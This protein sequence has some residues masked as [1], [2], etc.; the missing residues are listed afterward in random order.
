[1]S[2]LGEY[3]LRCE[4]AG[5]SKDVRAVTTTPEGYIV[6]ASRDT[7][8]KLWL[9]L[10]DGVHYE[11]KQ[12]YSGHTSYVS[13]VCVLPGGDGAQSE[14]PLV[15]TGS[16][17]TT[18]LVYPL[19]SNVP[20]HTLTGHSDTVSCLAWGEGALVSGS[21]DCTGRVWSGW[22]CIHELKGHEGPL[23][24][25]TI[26][27]GHSTTTILT[28][29]A[30]KTIRMW[31]G[32]KECH[33]F[34]GHKDCVRGLAVLSTD[35]FLSC[36][37]DATVILWSITGEALNT[38]EGHTNFIYG[39]ALICGEGD[40]VTG[41]E[42]RTVRVWS[43]SAGD[44]RQVIH[45]P[46]QSVWAVAALPN[47]DI[48]CGTSDG[49]CRV[50]S[51]VT[52]RQADTASQKVFEESVAKSTMAVGDLGGIKKSDLPG[53]EVLLTPGKKDGHTVMVREGDKINCYSW[54]ASKQEWTAVGE[55]VGGAGGSTSTSGKVLFEGKEY[56][57]V[58][59]VELDQGMF[60]KLPYNICEDPY[61]AA[62]RFIHHHELPQEFLDKVASF[63]IQNTKGTSLG[64]EG[65]GQ[66]SDPFTGGARYQPTT[67]DGSE[68]GGIGEGADPFT[69][70]GRYVPGG[71]SRG[72]NIGSVGVSGIPDPFT[73]ASSY[74]TPAARNVLAPSHFFPQQV[75]LRFEACNM[76]G[77]LSKL[78]ASN[79]AIDQSHQLANEKL[80]Q[81][82]ACV[83]EAEAS[84]PNHLGPLECAL[85]WPVEHVWPALDVLRLALLS[86]KMQTVWLDTDRRG[87]L[88]SHL[89]SF[90][91]L[92]SVPTAQM[93]AL[94][95]L[96]NL[97]THQPGRQALMEM[98]DK[99]ITVTVEIAPYQNKNA[100]IAASTVL[101][102]YTVLLEA[103]ENNSEENLDKKCQVM[104]GAGT[105]AMTAKDP[106][107]Q[108]RCLVALGTLLH[109][110][111]NNNNNRCR[112]LAAS[113]DLKPVVERLAKVT[114]PTKVGECASHL[115]QRL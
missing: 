12:T 23:W 84:D 15:A 50:F 106:E 17:D 22:Q 38:Y 3:R 73:G 81:L 95:C 54:S 114:S 56:D 48:V 55:V 78:T 13:S 1:M 82:V 16:R 4:L 41:G 61:Y 85:Q 39:L 69:G 59:D 83:S 63:I 49:M 14:G 45:M 20:S 51:K 111:H 67:G 24:A 66:F 97:S 113:L 58:F 9:P 2:G 29:S 79:S 28:A 44:C 99:I 90:V 100:E 25:I 102:N 47:A 21:W 96:A 46:A 7:T 110:S 19:H 26:L 65:T 105:V 115:L 18:I 37:N 80:E 68:A 53:K 91:Q 109:H 42:D 64:F 86:E 75:P 87:T 101:L 35:R 8:A 72:N 77:M 103:G 76:S 93:M 104:S 52:E 108:F 74:S 31:R 60:L 30:D 11:A 57:Y 6:T 98:W 40:V 32:D 88:V 107:A 62:Q 71:S 112:A 94:R 92:Q 36:S 43:G 5:H 10:P 34:N 89:I 70:G 33:K 27:P